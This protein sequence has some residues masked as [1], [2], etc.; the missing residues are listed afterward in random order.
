MLALNVNI[1]ID[2]KPINCI[3]DSFIQCNYSVYHIL[4]MLKHFVCLYIIF[5]VDLFTSLFIKRIFY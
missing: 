2:K 1:D 3:K 5:G 4:L